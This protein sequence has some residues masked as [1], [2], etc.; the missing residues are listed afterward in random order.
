MSS[1]RRLWNT[2]FGWYERHYTLNVGVA[3]GLFL[4]QLVHLYWL[5]ADVVAQRLTGE[6]YWEPTDIVRFLILI[7]DYTEIPALIATS[8]IYINELRRGWSWRNLL[9][10]V[11]LNSQWFHI[12]WI[13]D[14]FVVAEFGGEGGTALPGWLAWAAILIDY[15]ELPVIV[16]T[17]RRFMEALRERRLDEFLREDLA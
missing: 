1:L 11:F 7:V 10:L 9:F 15:L 14:E 13:T 16:D 17:L 8:L 6:S 5:S 2:F 3:A 12:F 4:L